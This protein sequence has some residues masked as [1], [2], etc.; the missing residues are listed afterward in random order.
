MTKKTTPRLILGVPAKPKCY[1]N[2]RGSALVKKSPT[3][4]SRAAY[5][6]LPPTDVMVLLRR[7]ETTEFE[8]EISFIKP[9]RATAAQKL[10]LVCGILEN[11]K[12][13]GGKSNIE[14][15]LQDKTGPDTPDGQLLSKSGKYTRLNPVIWSNNNKIFISL[16]R[17]NMSQSGAK[18]FV[19]AWKD[20]DYIENSMRRKSDFLMLEDFD[21][22]KQMS[23]EDKAYVM[24]RREHGE[25]NDITDTANTMLAL[26]GSEKRP[27]QMKQSVLELQTNLAAKNE[28]IN[29]LRELLKRREQELDEASDAYESAV[30]EEE[31]ISQRARNEYARLKKEET[32]INQARQDLREEYQR[33]MSELKLKIS[34]QLEEE[35]K[36]LVA[37]YESKQGQ[38]E[39]EFLP[40]MK[41]VITRIKEMEKELPELRPEDEYVAGSD[42]ESMEI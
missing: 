11:F 18:L 40:R 27:A 15:E 34:R 36:A 5:A 21:P 31:E 23:D 8:A 17:F 16:Q 24:F 3:S 20:R 13:H 4:P 41:L 7:N 1:I 33:Q 28:E 2:K 26:Q 42:A 19:K 10:E 22:S 25:T 32:D 30:H 6:A 29:E 37:D 39:E 12:A 38:Q 35:S 14:V 9:K